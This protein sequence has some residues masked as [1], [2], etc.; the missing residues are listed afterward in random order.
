MSSGCIKKM[1]SRREVINPEMFQ[2]SLL[3]LHA[4]EFIK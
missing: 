2:I 4:N 1:K 3:S